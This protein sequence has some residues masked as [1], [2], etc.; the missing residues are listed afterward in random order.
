MHTGIVVANDCD[1]RAC[2][3]KIVAHVTGDYSKIELTW[4][5]FG[6]HRVTFMGE[7]R[8]D[9]EAFAAKIGYTVV[10]ES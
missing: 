4:R 9:V 10:Y 1:D 7:F 6:W 8:A 2:R 5:N 3:T